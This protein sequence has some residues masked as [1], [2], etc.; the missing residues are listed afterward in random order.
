MSETIKR[1]M[2]WPKWW[3]WVHFAL[4]VLIP[5][6]LVTGW[7]LG[8]DLAVQ[9]NLY[10]QLLDEFHIPLGNLLGLAVLLRVFYLLYDRGVTG[11]R[12]L[13]LTPARREGAVAM[14]KFYLSFFRMPLPG[15]FSH[16]P[17]W[18]GLYLLFWAGLLLLV[19]TGVLLEQQPLR[20]LI[21]VSVE[22]LLD[23]HA[24]LAE[25]LAIF[26]AFHVF[27]AIMQDTKGK[28]G[29]I[30]ALF[31][32]SRYISIKKTTKKPVT[33]SVSIDIKDIKFNN[34]DVDKGTKE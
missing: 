2:V 21:G 32:G 9:N 29:D 24:W 23:M 1:I 28:G 33:S 34:G 14:L 15:Y 16:N 12:A 31:S 6:L 7:L 13:L 20:M 4:L 18:G 27:T 10:Q 17:L 26:I 30:S 19:G 3:R 22:N 25:A 5:V 11:Y 8:S